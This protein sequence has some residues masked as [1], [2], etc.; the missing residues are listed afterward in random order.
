MTTVGSPA[1]RWIG[2]LCS[3]CSPTS[4]PGAIDQAAPQ[5][6]PVQRDARPQRRCSLCRT[7]R[8]GRCQPVLFHSARPPQLSGAG[9]HA[10]HPRW[11]AAAR[12]DGSEA[13]GSLT[14]AA[15]LARSEDRAR[16]CLSPIRIQQIYRTVKPG[17]GS[18]L[19]WHQ[20]GILADPASGIAVLEYG[21]T[22]ILPPVG[23]ASTRP[24]RLC[25]PARQASRAHPRGKP[26]FLTY[27]NGFGRETDS[28]LERDGFETSVPGERA[29]GLNLCLSP[30]DLPFS[31]RSCSAWRAR[32]R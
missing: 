23:A 22:E 4:P 16:L 20:R 18:R 30:Y 17:E 28:P 29:Y 24:A 12:F 19:R 7:R 13:P 26:G 31:A 10:S 32:T 1:P 25:R 11:P 21:P 3:S 9:Y 15:C 27:E 6:A 14:S 8:A 2:P 5:G